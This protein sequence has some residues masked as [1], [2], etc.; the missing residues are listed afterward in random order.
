MQNAKLLNNIIHLSDLSDAAMNEDE[1]LL[2]EQIAMTAE[3]RKVVIEA[4]DKL[5]QRQREAVMLH[6]YDRLNVSETAEVMGVSQPAATIHLK[7]ARLRVKR[8]IESSA[9]KLITAMQGLVA[10]PLGDM[11]SRTLYTEGAMFVPA[12]QTWL[13]D[14]L[15]K[16]GDLVMVGAVTAGG[17]AGTAGVYTAV[18]GKAASGSASSIASA[19]KSILAAVTATVATLAITFGIVQWQSGRQEIQLPANATGGIVFSSENEVSFINPTSATASSDSRGGELYIH[20]WSI[21]TIDE[22]TVLYTGKS[23]VI[24]E[25]IFMSMHENH[26]YGSYELVFIMEDSNGTKY[27]LGHNFF[28]V[29]E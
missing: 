17:A 6:Y 22:G 12:N 9:G 20:Q 3:S 7:E 14:T 21:K 2:P 10:I 23:S 26:L 5:P 24:D 28:I 4:I 15:T 18:K 8:D 19:A 25:E 1:N 16:C 11:L 29:E 13:A 27:E